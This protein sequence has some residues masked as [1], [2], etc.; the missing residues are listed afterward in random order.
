[1]KPITT[2][3]TI[4]LTAIS[5][6]HFLRLILQVDIDVNGVNIPKVGISVT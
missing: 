2:I 4:L 1:M 3:V 5:I 6:A